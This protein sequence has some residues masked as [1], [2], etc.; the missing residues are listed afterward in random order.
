[1]MAAPA[2]A[3]VTSELELAQLPTIPIISDPS[4]PDVVLP[5]PEPQPTVEPLPSLEELLP[6][7]EIPP[8]SP[9]PILEENPGEIIIEQFKVI[10]STVFSAEELAA[11][12]EPFTKQAISFTELLQA[13]EAITELYRDQGYIT[14]GAFI[15]PQSLQEGTI[16]IQVVEGEV[17]AITIKN[18]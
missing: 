16:T 11:V 14:S 17:E 10:G 2:I 9:Q 13:Q 15:P 3:Q 5:E 18:T 12:L 4:T 1:M 7:L 8:N 6:Q